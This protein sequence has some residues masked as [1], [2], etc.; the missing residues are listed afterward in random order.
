MNNRGGGTPDRLW[1]EKTRQ[2]RETIG[3]NVL[4]AKNKNCVL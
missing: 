4:G 2:E 3:S 1:N